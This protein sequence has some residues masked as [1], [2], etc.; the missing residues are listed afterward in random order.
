MP[1]RYCRSRITT[2]K[3]TKF[4]FLKYPFSTCQR[5]FKSG[6]R[7]IMH[8]HD[9]PQIWL[10]TSGKHLH[11]IN[12]KSFI[13]HRGDI[14]IIPPGVSH[15]FEMNYGPSKL[16]CIEMSPEI[17]ANSNNDLNTM[18]HLFLAALY[19]N[20]SHHFHLSQ[21]SFFSALDICKKLSFANCEK[22]VF[23]SLDKLF[24]LPEFELKIDKSVA[25]ILINEKIEPILRI[26]TYINN[27]FSQK[28]TIDEILKLSTL[29]RTHFFKYFKALTGSSF[30]AYLQEIRL[31]YAFIL[32]GN[33]N[34]PLNHI[35]TLC[36]FSDAYYMTNCYKKYIGKSPHLER[37]AVR[38]AFDMVKGQRNMEEKKWKT[39]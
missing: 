30:S 20:F 28:I 37:P 18:C 29:C 10:C 35:A 3:F 11:E 16:Y 12:G 33:S 23:K 31:A 4:F 9:F 8:V 34:Y 2:K 27:N 26:L 32:I 17:F 38:E 15:S 1:T 13:C 7:Q 25:K 36:G 22:D 14:L 5:M 19:D 21:A 6:Y 24:S 39:C